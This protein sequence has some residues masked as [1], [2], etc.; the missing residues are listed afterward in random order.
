MNEE[1]SLQELP[2]PQKKKREQRKKTKEPPLSSAQTD[3]D[4]KGLSISVLPKHQPDPSS[5]YSSESLA[6]PENQP[7][8]VPQARGGGKK[9]KQSEPKQSQS[10]MTTRRGSKKA[11]EASE[12]HISIENQKAARSVSQA[13]NVKFNEKDEVKILPQKRAKKSQASINREEEV[14]KL[15]FKIDNCKAQVSIQ[16]HKISRRVAHKGAK[17]SRQ[18]SSQRTQRLKGI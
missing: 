10:Q 8:K 14:Q 3:V 4:M 11:E 12:T 18:V 9:A 6:L 2:G 16:R 13:K 17:A 7:P 5:T 1:V 15:P